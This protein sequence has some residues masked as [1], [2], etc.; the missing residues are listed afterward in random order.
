VNE[1]RREDRP[2]RILLQTTIPTASDDWSIQR[3]SLLREHLSSLRDAMGAPL[4]EVAVRNR[5]ALTGGDDP[6]LSSL[7]TLDFDEVWLFAVDSGD[8]LS[9]NDCAAIRRFHARGGGLLTTRDHE[10]L[11]SS[12]VTLGGVGAAHFFHTRNWDPDPLRCAIDDHETQTISWPNYH[13]GRNGDYQPILAV[14]P[15]HELLRRPDTAAGVICSF[16]AHPHEGAVGVPEDEPNARVIATGRSQITGSTFNLAVAFERSNANADGCLGRGVAESSFHHFVDYNWD[17]D[18]GAPSFVIEPV[19]DGTKRSPDL[20]D[21]IKV[22]VR[23]LAAW[24]AP[25]GTNHRC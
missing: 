9:A 13:S 25:A 4:C 7:D 8:G 6:V 2:L 5:E 20:L 3:F 21:D 24:L 19:G 15:V 1:F 14:A 22:Y 23:N 11:G 12:L 17:P 10:D 18:R 16:P